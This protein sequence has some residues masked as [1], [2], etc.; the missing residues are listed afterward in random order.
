LSVAACLATALAAAPAEAARNKCQKDSGRVAATSDS[1]VVFNT[2]SAGVPSL[3]A[4]RFSD[5]RL[6][7]KLGVTGG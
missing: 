7:L 2:T 1:S 4:C 3:G 5:G 6:L